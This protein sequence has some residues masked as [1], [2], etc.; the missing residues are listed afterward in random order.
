[1]KQTE[2]KVNAGSKFAVNPRIVYNFIYI[3]IWLYNNDNNNIMFIIYSHPHR[4]N[5]Q[6]STK[7]QFWFANRIVSK[8]VVSSFIRCINCKSLS[9]THTHTPLL[10]WLV[11]LAKCFIS[12]SD[13]RPVMSSRIIIV[14]VPSLYVYVCMYVYAVGDSTHY[15]QDKRTSLQSVREKSNNGLV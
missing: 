8:Q 4:Y 10:L 15:A 6:F 3:F 12:W 11:S 9:H 5:L 13:G 2:S 14:I 1:M 7:T